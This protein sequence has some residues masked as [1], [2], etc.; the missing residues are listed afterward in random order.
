[1][2]RLTPAAKYERR[3]GVRYAWLVDQKFRRHLTSIEAL[4]AE[5]KEEQVA[6]S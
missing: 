6:A 5:A 4:E 2:K 1:M 3:L